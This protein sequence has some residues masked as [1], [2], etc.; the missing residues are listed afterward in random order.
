MNDTLNILTKYGIEF[1]VDCKKLV[2]ANPYNVI[3]MPKHELEKLSH[4]EIV[5][6]IYGVNDS[7]IHLTFMLKNGLVKEEDLTIFIYNNYI[8]NNTFA[9]IFK[10]INKDNI[11]KFINTIMHKIDVDSDLFSQFLIDMDLDISIFAMNGDYFDDRFIS[12]DLNSDYYTKYGN[13]LIDLIIDNKKYHLLNNM[14]LYSGDLDCTRLEKHLDNN[15]LIS[16]MINKN[17]YLDYL[18]N[19]HI[20]VYNR[21]LKSHEFQY[22]YKLFEYDINKHKDLSNI[23]LYNHIVENHVFGFIPDSSNKTISLLNDPSLDIPIKIYK[24]YAYLIYH[25]DVKNKLLTSVTDFDAPLIFKWVFKLYDD[26][27]HAKN[28]IDNMIQT[29]PHRFVA[30]LH[31][32]YSVDQ[33]N[34]VL[35]IFP[36][37]FDYIDVNDYIIESLRYK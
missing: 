1:N 11:S 9:E 17:G 23:E 15:T 21:I 35:K 20:D 4:D 34:K 3:H 30:N 5:D 31:D 6:I 10:L 16:S 27:I 36:N 12:P 25:E 22:C 19:N 26:N 37:L 33:L 8:N 24:N 2:K 32:I 29:K 13:D 7:N 28:I 18:Y 14:S